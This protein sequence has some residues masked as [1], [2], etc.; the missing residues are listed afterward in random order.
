MKNF[1]Y[2]RLAVRLLFF[3][4]VCSAIRQPA[5]ANDWIYT[6]RPGDNLWNLTE[7]YLLDISYVK[8][9]QELNQVK[10]PWHIPPGSKL[11]IPARWI[12]K[13]PMLVR[14]LSIQGTAQLIDGHDSSTTPVTPGTLVIAGDAIETGPDSTVVLQFIDG[15][16][17]TLQSESQLQFNYLMLFDYTGM[18]DT[19]MHLRRGRVEIRVTPNKGSANR[20]EIITPAAVTAVRGTNYRISAETKVVVSRTEVLVGS[21]GV[22]SSGTSRLIPEGYGTVTVADHPPEPPVELLDP[23]DIQT[24]PRHF[25]QVPLQF[26]MPPLP[27]GQGYRMQIAK[28]AAFT[29]VLFDRKY[30]TAL[31]RGPDLPDGDYQLRIRGIDRQGLEGRNAGLQ[32]RLNARPEAPFLLEPRPDLGVVVETPTFTWSGRKDIHAYH[33][34]IARN[35]DFLK[36]VVDLENYSGVKLTL[37]SPLQLGKYYWRVAAVDEQEGAGPF[38]DAQGFRRINPAPEIEE[39]EISEKFLVIRSRAGLPGQRYHF[40]LAEDI[41]FTI[42]LLDQQTTQP[43]VKI[44]RPD[45]GAYF[46]RVR[47]ID[48]D[49][50]SGP[51]GK[52]QEIDI[53]MEGLY[54]WLLLLPLLALIAI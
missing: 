9:L 15:S 23:P 22:T 2:Y 26:S 29:E 43:R 18:I 4:M 47:T 1:N 7:Q 35:V 52:P 20:F 46:V 44:L 37:E 28:T 48:P 16:K 33:F 8:K 49:G 36:P 53:P 51:F 31:I 45:S 41:E 21:V 27:D 6:V 12:K 34:Q 54:W 17:L 19:S 14:V 10:D 39:S 40:Q 11:K 3:C 13:Y 50:F 32:V 38:S 25:D 30:S 5:F 42:L 24:V